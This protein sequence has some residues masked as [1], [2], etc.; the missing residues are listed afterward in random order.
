MADFWDYIIWN[1]SLKAYILVAATVLFV[2][3][4]KRFLSRLIGR[5]LFSFIR[6]MGSG[7]DRTD[8]LRLVVGPIGTFLVVVVSMSS[9]EKLHFPGALDFDIY[10]VKSKVLIHGLGVII[11]IGSF[12]WLLLR[13]VD[14][15]AVVLRNK[16]RA[17]RV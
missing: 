1:N 7:L 9:L 15:I 17:G 3:I 5:F 13:L 11:I 6:K 16:A 8:F 2:I 12:I 4:L 14:F 10:E